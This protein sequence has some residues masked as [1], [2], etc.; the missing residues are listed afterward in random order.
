MR[1]S[2]L[3]MMTDN[4][5]KSDI[6]EGVTFCQICTRRIDHVKTWNQNIYANGVAGESS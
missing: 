3:D 5:R 1:A 2:T 6:S 4:F